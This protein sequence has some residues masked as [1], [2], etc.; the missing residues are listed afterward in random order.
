MSFK[1]ALCHQLESNKFGSRDGNGMGF[2]RVPIA[3]RP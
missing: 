1:L 3:P 2:F